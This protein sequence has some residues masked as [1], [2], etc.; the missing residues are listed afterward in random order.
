MNAGELSALLTVVFSS[1]ETN[2]ISMTD[3]D[4]S[5]L[6]DKLWDVSADAADVATNSHPEAALNDDEIFGKFINQ[7][8][9]KNLETSRLSRNSSAASV[10]TV[11]RRKTGSLTGWSSAMSEPSEAQRA[12]SGFRS[13]AAVFVSLLFPFE[14]TK[15]QRVVVCY[16]AALKK[17]GGV[18]QQYSVDDK[19]QTLLAIFGLPLFEGEVVIIAAR[20]MTTAKAKHI[21]VMDDVTFECIKLSNQTIDLGFVKAKGRANGVHAYGINLDSDG[22]A[23][24]QLEEVTFGYE[25]E[26]AIISDKF[27]SWCKSGK[28]AVVVVE[29]ASGLGK[30]SLANFVINQ[31]RKAGIPTAYQYLQYFVLTDVLDILKIDFSEDEAMSLMKKSDVY[32]FLLYPDHQQ[33]HVEVATP[34]GENV[35]DGHGASYEEPKDINGVRLS[36][37]HIG[38]LNAIYDSLSFEER[39]GMS[40]FVAEVLESLLNDDNQDS[41]LPSIEFHFSRAGNVDKIIYYREKLGLSQTLSTMKLRDR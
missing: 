21:L 8:L 18:F 27:E 6:Y 16:L 5:E 9:L 4:I 20:L 33:N 34:P 22:P 30:S 38:I 26:R 11:R 37:R 31:A 3:H 32:S 7:S 12:D 13:V 36:F 10:P 24:E 39:I 2:L 23:R 35:D 14:L 17:F 28:R 1:D 41:L 15:V 25:R 40:K 29:A 19:G